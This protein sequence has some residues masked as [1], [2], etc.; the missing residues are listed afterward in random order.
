VSPK[1]FL[2]GIAG[3]AAGAAVAIGVAAAAR[4]G[5][6]DAFIAAAHLPPLLTAPGEDVTLRYELVCPPRDGDLSSGD[7]CDGGGDV[8]V[9]AGHAGVFRR[10]RL[11]RGDDAADGRYSVALPADIAS[12]PS[13]FSYY[14]VLRDNAHG[15][16][17]TLPAAGGD[18]PQNSYRLA[19][20]VR[21][22]LGVHAFGETRA[23]DERVMDAT[24]GSRLGD[25][26]LGGGVGDA[27]FGPSAFDVTR[28]GTVSLL[29]EV[30]RR[31]E[32]FRHGAVKATPIDVP[33]VLDDMSVGAD[34]TIYVV[35]GR[36]DNGETPLLRTFDADGRLRR[37]Q[38]LAERTWSQLRVG[39]NGPVVQQHPSEQWMPPGR[40]RDG[41]AGRP[42]G[43]GSR[44]VV[45]R[46]GAGEL[47]I[48]RVV[49]GAVHDAWRFTS[50]TPLGEVQ[51]VERIGGRLVVVVKT[52]TE[53]E[54]EFE[55]VVV[56]AGGAQ[57]RF[58]VPSAEW[59]ET[60]PL[61]RFRFD[62]RFLYQFG[63]TP[64]SVFVDRFDLGGGA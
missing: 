21:V 48:A 1:T 56:D 14:A 57:R 54:D 24:W 46:V 64:N 35:D 52:Y 8:Y 7:P 61:A 28:D 31:V 5:G 3:L 13:G 63:S 32:R 58:S 33:P 19:D 60:A 45:L 9:R 29:D 59:A 40:A 16:S 27:R 49:N 43:D 41:F 39:P 34:G 47:R 25:V 26:G 50:D 12:S 36:S 4:G 55:V 2:C 62:G 22:D 11:I 37:T 15:T 51:L 30:N 10:L 20:P 38:H 53:R 17:T 23:A 42:L 18:A 44:L 6:T